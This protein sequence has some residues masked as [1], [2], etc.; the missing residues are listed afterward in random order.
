MGEGAWGHTPFKIVTPRPLPYQFSEGHGLGPGP[1]TS[2]P[3]RQG[4]RGL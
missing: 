2:Q 3:C 1:V 4:R